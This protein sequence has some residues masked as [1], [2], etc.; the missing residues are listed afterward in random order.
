MESN[1]SVLTQKIEALDSRLERQDSRLERLEEAYT[2][3]PVILAEIAHVLKDKDELSTT[4]EKLKDRVIDLEK[5]TNVNSLT[6]A[7]A[8][9]FIWILI[10]VAATAI[11][12]LVI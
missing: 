8:E 2:Q 7:K 11:G 6:L 1:L 3:M 10:A 4:V 12:K 9:R 5:V